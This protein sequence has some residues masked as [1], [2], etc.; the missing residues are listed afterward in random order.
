MQPRFFGWRGVFHC[1]PMWDTIIFVLH[2]SFVQFFIWTWLGFVFYSIWVFFF[3]DAV[4]QHYR[5]RYIICMWNHIC[6]RGRT[7]CYFFFILFCYFAENYFQQLMFLRAFRRFIHFL[8]KNDPIWW[9]GPYWI[10]DALGLVFFNMYY[11]LYRI[12][13][14]KFCWSLQRSGLGDVCWI[15]KSY[16]PSFY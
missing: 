2:I 4:F 8:T 15:I 9:V 11:T 1:N 10:S 6:D 13:A 12:T 5:R 3:S 14:A 16:A 7:E